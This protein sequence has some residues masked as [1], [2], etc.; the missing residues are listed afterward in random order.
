MTRPD[1]RSGSRIREHYEIERELADRLREAPAEARLKLY[2]E[3]YDELFRRVPDHPQHAWKDDPATRALEVETQL[4]VLAPYLRA[5]STYM[6]IGA[7]DCAL[8]LAVAGRARR[9]YAVDVSAEITAGLPQTRS[10]ELVLSDG[11]SIPVPAGTVDLAYSNQLMEHLHPADA[12][13]QLRNIHA[14][15]APG[16]AYVC[17]TPHRLYGPSD[18]SAGF[19]EVASGFH[20]HEYTVA[21][22]RSLC[23]RVGFARM[24][25][26]LWLRWRGLAVPTALP[27]ALERLL[28]PLPHRLRARIGSSQLQ[29]LLGITLVAHKRR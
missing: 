4:R 5:D 6:E 21:E 11:V 9:V 29:R 27:I 8:A 23:G 24:R 3:V 17:T 2:P 18:I 1:L 25:F 12:E 7:G 10:F 20:L 14:A 26:I 28:A 16:S 19:D 13:A 15:L 22:L